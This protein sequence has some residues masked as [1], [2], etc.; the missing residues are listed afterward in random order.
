MKEKQIGYSDISA[1]GINRE[2]NRNGNQYFNL[3]DSGLRKLAGKPTG[4]IKFSDFKGKSLGIKSWRFHE[5]DWRGKNS[6]KLFYLNAYDKNGRI[7]FSTGERSLDGENNHY[8]G[9]CNADMKDI[10]R[11]DLKWYR[12]TRSNGTAKMWLYVTD[13]DNVEHLILAY[14]RNNGS[15]KAANTRTESITLGNWD[16]SQRS[17]KI[18][19]KL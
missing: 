3:N 8:S 12:D 9:V 2:A 18:E 5:Y 16:G 10:V 13:H 19:T 6:A 7:V 17:Y 15:F 11:V 14:D 4:E 1:T